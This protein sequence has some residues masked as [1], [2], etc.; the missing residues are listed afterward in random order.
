M[1]VNARLLKTLG[2]SWFVF[3]L[4]GIAI[5]I[6]LPM[7]KL[8][9]LIDRSYCEPARWHQVA[10]AYE[11]LY[12]QHQQQALQIDRVVLFSD[13]GE[14]IRTELPSPLEI[15]DTRT[16]GRQA[17]QQQQTLQQKYP[18]AKLLRCS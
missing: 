15:R 13:L 6:F 9:V 17:Q 8:T 16:Y 7:P 1:T 11:M 10:D 5:A 14:D 12:E 3:A 4:A 2:L 18:Q